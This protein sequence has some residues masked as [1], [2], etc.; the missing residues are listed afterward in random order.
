MASKP[1]QIY[2]YIL[3]INNQINI[4]HRFFAQF[5]T[6]AGGSGSCGWKQAV[7][8]QLCQCI[9]RGYHNKYDLCRPREQRSLSGKCVNSVQK[10]LLW[11]M[12]INWK[13]G[14][15]FAPFAILLGG[16][17]R[18]TA[19]QTRLILDPGWN[20]KFRNTVRTAGL[21]RSLRTSVWVSGLD[22]SPSWRSSSQL[23]VF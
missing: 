18:T 12:Q 17:W 2:I 23:C 1:Q 14:K 4:S 21:S 7:Q 19:V 16:L 5:S 11:D 22:H 3:L 10:K 6:P 9:R 15:C 20:Y 8:L 13:K